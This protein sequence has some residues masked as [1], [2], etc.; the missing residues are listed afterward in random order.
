M[1]WNPTCQDTCP[2]RSDL[3]AKAP[4]RKIKNKKI[5]LKDAR[6]LGHRLTSRPTSIRSLPK[7]IASPYVSGVKD[8]SWLC[9]HDIVSPRLHALFAKSG[10]EVQSI[11]R[12]LADSNDMRRRTVRSCS[13]FTAW[14]IIFNAT[15]WRAKPRQSTQVLR[16]QVSHLGRFCSP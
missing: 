16:L 12:L 11:L 7:A 5:L 9:A 13:A 2:N 6:D 10:T 8:G 15:A 1:L 4:S 14:R 3:I